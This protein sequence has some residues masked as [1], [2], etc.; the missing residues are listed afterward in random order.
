M[1]RSITAWT[2]AGYILLRA[3]VVMIDSG[4]GSGGTV[5]SFEGGGEHRPVQLG[6]EVVEAG[7]VARRQQGA[8]LGVGGVGDGL[9]LTEPL[10]ARWGHGDMDHAPVG[11]V[12]GP[13]DEAARLHPVEVVGDRRAR[14]V[15]TGRQ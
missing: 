12:A 3:R 15:H 1:S 10:G 5:F 11:V 9:E 8:D 14:Q 13:G 4:A 7:G 6:E 2:P